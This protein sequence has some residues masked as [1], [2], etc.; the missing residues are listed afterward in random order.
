MSTT[1]AVAD[2]R[3]PD[4]ASRAIAGGD[5]AEDDLVA[6]ALAADVDADIPADAVSLWDLDAD[7]S[8]LLPAWYMP[9]PAAGPS[10]ASTTTGWRRRMIVL[11]FV[12]A[13]VLIN[14]A[15]L[16]VTYGRVVLA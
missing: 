5:L 1:S 15:G 4:R 13:L 10:T 12:L 14:A 7:R 11:T 2:R 16:C 3:R 9:T 6:Q 8:G